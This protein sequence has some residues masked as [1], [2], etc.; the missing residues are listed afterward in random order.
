MQKN[1]SLVNLFWNSN[2]ALSLPTFALNLLLAA[3]L[4]FLL[5]E[6]YA[7]FGHALSNRRSFA[8]NFL[9][10][11][12]TTTVVISIVKSSLALSLGLVGALSIVRF[13]AAIKEP[14]ELAYLFFA[15][16]IGL[17]LGAGQTLITLA[18]FVLIL[19][20]LLV[21]RLGR[22]GSVAANLHLTIS[23]P[24]PQKL[25]VTQLLELLAQCGVA[26]SLKRFEETP[27][28]LEASFHVAFPDV[29]KLQEVNRRLRALD[30]R[31][32]VSYLE[33]RGLGN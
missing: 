20:C 23:A 1:E 26:A 8:R 12:L 5:G 9:L 11:T 19:G 3:V 33:D 16:S 7:R 17:G 21:R 13:R 15:I 22:R 2:T 29:T 10:L 30:D 27:D 31:V 32:R 25:N 4:A 18:A 6:F 28:A 24:A 14:E